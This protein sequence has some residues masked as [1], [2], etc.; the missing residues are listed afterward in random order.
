MADDFDK[1]KSEL[2]RLQKSVEDLSCIKEK[3]PEK[4]DSLRD[5]VDKLLKTVLS[6]PDAWSKDQACQSDI[7][8]KVRDELPAK[9]NMLKMANAELDNATRELVIIN[10]IAILFLIILT[11][12]YIWL[13]NNHHIAS[14]DKRKTQEFFLN[15]GTAKA[16]LA[17]SSVTLEEINSALG[18][19]HD[20]PADILTSEFKERISFLKGFSS[21][22][23]EAPK[24]NNITSDKQTVQSAPK[25]NDVSTITQTDQRIVVIKDEIDKIDKEART[26]SKN[27]GFFWI[28]GYW[29]WLEIVFW[30][31]FGVIVGI[32]V[33][34]CSQAES[35][36][37]TKGMFKRE[38]YWYLTEIVIGPIVVI[39]AFFLLKQTIGT[40]LMGITEEE[41]RGSI[42][43][44][45][46]VSFTLGLFIRRTL[47]IFNFIKDKLPLPQS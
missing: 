30:G 33:W 4:Y 43:L 15:I 24:Q 34:V 5:E 44:T 17:K 39:A 25:K 6:T 12:G 38:I 45:L 8:K 1:I 21:T 36:K 11:T 32:L 31:E 27:D 29:K 46:G 7:I 22:L 3:V 26:L 10:A 14:C 28:T 2:E 35:G 20:D 16:V 41:V 23:Q 18:K 9:L 42:Y 19:F 13:H 37:Y 47:G 40:M